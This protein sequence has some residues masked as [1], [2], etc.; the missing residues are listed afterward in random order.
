MALSQM[1]DDLNIIAGL[2]D[3]PNSDNGLSSDALKAKFDEG[4]LLLQQFINFQIVAFVNDLEQTIKN[5]TSFN[6]THGSLNGRNEADQHSIEAITGL[7][8]ALSATVS[9]ARGGTGATDAETARKN[10][11]LGTAAVEDT[12]PLAKGGTGA[13]TAANARDN[14]GLG[15]VAVE[16]VLPTTKGGTGAANG[17]TGLQNLFAAGNT[18]LSAYQYGDT[19]PEVGVAGRI[20]FKKVEQ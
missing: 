6:G 20:F 12:V 1:T 7:K 11:G 16:N 18:V 19:L 14:L 13:S 4:N 10:L 5:I 3:N 2:W 9:V 8:E 17:A 15:A